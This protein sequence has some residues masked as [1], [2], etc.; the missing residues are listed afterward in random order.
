MDLKLY[1]SIQDPSPASED[2]LGIRA[3]LYSP[4]SNLLGKKGKGEEFISIS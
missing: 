1:L 4:V 2:T 3:L